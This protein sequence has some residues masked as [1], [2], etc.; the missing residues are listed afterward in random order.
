MWGVLCVWRVVCVVAVYT[1]V[2][3]YVCC[4]CAVCYVIMCMKCA[5]YVYMRAC[6]R[7]CF[8]RECILSIDASV[9]DRCV[10]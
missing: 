9:L 2:I 5:A 8:L 7:V 4:M 3:V 1:Q 10:L 6:V